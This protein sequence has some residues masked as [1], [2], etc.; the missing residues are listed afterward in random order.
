MSIIK[1]LIF[2]TLIYIGYIM[3]NKKIPG[4][5][6][7][8][9]V[10]KSILKKPH[11][12]YYDV[13]II[14]HDMIRNALVEEFIKYRDVIFNLSNLPV[15]SKPLKMSEG[16]VLATTISS[17]FNKALEKY[18]TKLNVQQ[19]IPLYKMETD[20]ESQYSFQIEYSISSLQSRVNVENK[21]IRIQVVI[22]IHKKN[23]SA[24]F[25]DKVLIDTTAESTKNID[26]IYITQI[27]EI[28][29]ME[30]DYAVGSICPSMSY[31]DEVGN[32]HADEMDHRYQRK[33]E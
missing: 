25:F 2:V 6:K 30:N 16:S 32:N 17:N 3:W 28:K 9:K 10:I 26:K 22:V 27:K 20:I 5:I 31:I 11:A 21:I 19:V 15:S 4:I 33:E 18:A 14:T 1:T 8:H 13:N 24:T 7:K 23:D 29:T 12:Q